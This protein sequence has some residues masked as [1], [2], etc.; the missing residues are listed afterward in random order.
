MSTV[1]INLRAE[2]LTRGKSAE[3]MAEAIGVSKRVLLAAEK[4]VVPRPESALKIASFYGY[5]VTDIWP[6]P[7]H[8]EASA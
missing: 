7:E 2:R 4:R 5:Q 1:R 8:A 6:V 3:R